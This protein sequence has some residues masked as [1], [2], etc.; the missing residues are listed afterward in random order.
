MNEIEP[1]IRRINSHPGVVGI[2]IVLDDGTIV[3]SSMDEEQTA[4]YSK[5]VTQ[6]ASL[7]RSAVRDLDPTNE[8]CHLRIAS[9]KRE[10]LCIP[11]DRYYIIVATSSTVDPAA[12]TK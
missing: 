9:D 3:R 4:K 7:C 10:I 2:I 1:T 5:H 11:E 12:F 8:L 6:F